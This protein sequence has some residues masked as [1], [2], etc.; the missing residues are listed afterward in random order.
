MSLTQK[1]AKDETAEVIS[2]ETQR[3]AVPKANLRRPSR[4][5]NLRRQTRRHTL[6]M[7]QQTILHG[8]R[9]GKTEGGSHRDE[10]GDQSARAYLVVDGSSQYSCTTPCTIELPPGRHTIAATREGYRRTLEDL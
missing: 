10:D 5:E 6:P 4:R 7:R 1:A 8:H 2:A 3:D 9:A